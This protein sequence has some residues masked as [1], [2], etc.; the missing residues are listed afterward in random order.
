[1]LGWVV[2]SIYQGVTLMG[3]NLSADR[4]VSPTAVKNKRMCVN[5]GSEGCPP[6]RRYIS[7]RSGP[8]IASSGGESAS[9]STNADASSPLSRLP[10]TG[11][12]SPQRT[13][14]SARGNPHASAA[15]ANVASQACRS[16]CLRRRCSCLVTDNACGADGQP[17]AM[18]IA[19]QREGAVAQAARHA[20]GP[21]LFNG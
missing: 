14:S 20:R 3:A 18:L 2:C 13:R 16:Q 6:F 17:V 4:S 7:E 10:T 11:L 8:G 12:G 21:Q 1:M 15:T 5:F 9:T 19:M